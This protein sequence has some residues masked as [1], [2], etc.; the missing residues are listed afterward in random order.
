LLRP[1]NSSF[2]FFV[3]DRGGH[4]I[5]H[6]ASHVSQQRMLVSYSQTKPSNSGEKIDSAIE[7]I[8]G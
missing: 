1:Y 5:S 8:E 7:R 6:Y 2:I 3:P 4:S